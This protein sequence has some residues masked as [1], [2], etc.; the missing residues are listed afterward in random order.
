MLLVTIRSPTGIDRKKHPKTV[1]KVPVFSRKNFQTK[2]FSLF[3][4]WNVIL[5]RVSQTN[6][7]QERFQV[8]GVWIVVLFIFE[9]V[10]SLKNLVKIKRWKPL[11]KTGRIKNRSILQVCK[12]SLHMLNRL[13]M[14]I[15]PEKISKFWNKNNAMKKTSY[16][17]KLEGN[18]NKNN[19]LV[20]NPSF[21]PTYLFLFDLSIEY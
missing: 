15:C 4:H 7:T 3:Y 19:C 10:V 13:W 17:G 1:G 8:P 21:I 2:H 20:S 5:C 14:N 11:L 18:Q 16:I 6:L 12:F 9:T